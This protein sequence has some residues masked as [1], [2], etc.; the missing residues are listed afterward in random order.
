MQKSTLFCI[1]QTENFE[2][3]FAGVFDAQIRGVF[4]IGAA[5]I[6]GAREYVST[7]AADQPNDRGSSNKS[8]KET[9]ANFSPARIPGKIVY[10][11]SLLLLG[12]LHH[13]PTS[14]E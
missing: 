10:Y 11:A 14:R 2:S 4:C 8:N 1:L 7:R 9:N 12:R 6:L 3:M 13:S 5:T